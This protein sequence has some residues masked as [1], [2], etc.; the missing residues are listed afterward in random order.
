MAKCKCWATLWEDNQ[1][2]TTFLACPECKTF[3]KLIEYLPPKYDV[4]M[5]VKFDTLNG[6]KVGD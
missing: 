2:V 6:I 3:Y 4:G 5:T 1:K